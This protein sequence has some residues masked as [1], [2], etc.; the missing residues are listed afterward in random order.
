M[1]IHYWSVDG[2][3][4]RFDEIKD[5]DYFEK[6]VRFLVKEKNEAVLET[7]KRFDDEAD[8][9]F[10]E[11]FD[12][13]RF[14][15]NYEWQ[16]GEPLEIELAQIFFEKFGIPVIY[17]GV[18]DYRESAL[19]FTPMYPWDAVFKKYGNVTRDQV[20]KAFEDFFA[21]I[22]IEDVRIDYQEVEMWG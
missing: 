5:P 17:S 19:L 3:G 4:V 21:E 15:E 1:S 10:D 9:V 16:F 2:F 22:G 7:L 18:N 20:V 13:D 14:E 11:E 8:A 12:F 6:L